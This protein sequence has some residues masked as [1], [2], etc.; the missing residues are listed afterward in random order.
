MADERRTPSQGRSGAAG[1]R[2]ARRQPAGRPLADQILDVAVFAPIGLVDLAADQLAP[3]VAQGRDR[4]GRR[5]VAARMVGKMAVT[6]A[7]RRAEQLLGPGA[8]P[9]SG[10]V[11]PVARS[12]SQGAEPH[13]AAPTAGRHRPE[14]PGGGTTRDRGAL[15]DV[16]GLA[17]PSYDSLAASQVV[18]RLDALGSEELEAV[19]RY[20]EATRGRRTILGRVAQLQGHQGGAGGRD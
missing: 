20:E 8:G 15:P 10:A 12:T 7:R 18:R 4:V 19:R 13:G 16:A 2:G 5:L 17:I 11:V 9:S 6:M 1:E 14:R 3:L